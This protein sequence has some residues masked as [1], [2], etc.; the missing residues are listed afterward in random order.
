MLASF[1]AWSGA[2]VTGGLKTEGLELS[3]YCLSSRGIAVV[4]GRAC[5][6]VDAGWA[7]AVCVGRQKLVLVQPKIA[8]R[9]KTK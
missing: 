3:L 2:A 7:S 1:S 6:S 9:V 4:S 8:R 5:D